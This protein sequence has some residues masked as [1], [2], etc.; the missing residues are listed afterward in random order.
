LLV[1]KSVFFVKKSRKS[2]SGSMM[3][4]FHANRGGRLAANVPLRLGS[5]GAG[6]K[7]YR[8]LKYSAFPVKRSFPF[9]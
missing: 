2:I 7:N 9:P 5:W 6:G 4:N 3:L 1:K 8:T